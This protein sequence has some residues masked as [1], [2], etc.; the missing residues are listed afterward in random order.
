MVTYGY[1]HNILYIDDSFIRRSNPRFAPCEGCIS[2]F[3]TSY[4]ISGIDLISSAV[5]KQMSNPRNPFFFSTIYA[6][7]SVTSI[8]L[9]ERERSFYGCLALFLK[10]WI[11]NEN[12]TDYSYKKIQSRFAEAIKSLICNDNLFVE[13]V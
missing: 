6:L 3:F 4:C 8:N 1:T 13:N 5:T 9:S 7:L 10:Y 2:L 12:F 11:F